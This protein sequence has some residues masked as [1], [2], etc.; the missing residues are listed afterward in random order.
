V[1]ARIGR[2]ELLENVVVTY[3]ARLV[4][5]MKAY[6]NADVRECWHPHEAYPRSVN[7]HALVYLRH[8]DGTQMEMYY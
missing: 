5:I 8:L 7:S 3:E 6:S 4:D 2:F 1:R